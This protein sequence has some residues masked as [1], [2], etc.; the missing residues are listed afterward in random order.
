VCHSYSDLNFGV[1]FLE[2]S[3]C[4]TLTLLLGVRIQKI[5]VAV[6]Y[7]HDHFNKASKPRCHTVLYVPLPLYHSHIYDL[8]LWPLTLKTF[9][10]IPIHMISV[11]HVWKT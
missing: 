9:W 6:L 7:Y 8:D 10:A 2:H 4:G 11:S 1:T 3:V 5:K